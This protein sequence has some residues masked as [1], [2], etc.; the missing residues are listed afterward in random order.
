MQFF[1]ADFI[2]DGY[3]FLPDKS[4]LV[5]D[6]QAQVIDIL[7]HAEPEGVK[8]F[9][10]LLMPCMINTHCHLELSHFKGFIE[11]KEGLVNFLLKVNANRNHFSQEQITTSIELAEK[12]MIRNG[13]I[14]VGDI[15]NTLDTLLQ[16]SKKKLYYR[17]FVECFG[18]LD[19]QAHERFENGKALYNEFKTNQIAS[20]VLHAPYSISDTLIQRVNDFSENEISCIHNQES[21]DE[22]ELFIKGSGS[23]IQLFNAIIHESAF[24]KPSGKSS[25]QTYL[26]KLTT[27]QKIILVHNT[28]T[29]AE[30][31]DFA[32]SLG[33]ELF[34]CLCPNAN[35]YIEDSL[36]DVAMLIKKGCSIVLGT[37]SLASNHQLNLLDEMKT[38]Q[39][40]FPEILLEDQLRWVTSNGAM[41]LGMNDFLGSFEKGKKPGLLQIKHVV[42]KDKLPL[43]KV[44]MVRII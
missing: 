32:L 10:G 12:E 13:I 7:Q 26:P 29:S 21:R 1:S 11:E 24:F 28:F 18:L 42:S 15:S 14:A 22:N 25:L 43:E 5:M 34:W 27:Q 9:E 31:I 37:D 2:F 38:L 44:E 35:L 40:H 33:K 8:H 41:A 23:F 30:D 3:S 4:I 6:E 19:I 39:T 16:K 36:P 17:T 20:I